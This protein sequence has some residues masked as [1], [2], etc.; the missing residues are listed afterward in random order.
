MG[1]YMIV[2]ESAT[3]WYVKQGW[4][5]VFTGESKAECLA[6]IEENK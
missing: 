1:K 2:R 3:R 5:I 6:W 4:D